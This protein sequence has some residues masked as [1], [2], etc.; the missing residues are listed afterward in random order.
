MTDS[1]H[2]Q[3]WDGRSARAASSAIDDTV[4]PTGGDT[5]LDHSAT[6]TPRKSTQSILQ[7]D[8]DAE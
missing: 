4:S 6:H 5:E 8:S 3:R 1:D 2:S 7:C